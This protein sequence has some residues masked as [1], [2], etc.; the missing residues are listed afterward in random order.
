MPVISANKITPPPPFDGGKYLN[1]QRE[2]QF[3]RDIYWF[4]DD[5]Q[6]L[7]VTG[8]HANS[9]LRKFLIQFFRQT[10]EDLRKRTIKE[11]LARMLKHFSATVKEREAY[12]VGE[13]LP[14]KRESSESIQGFWFKYDEM[15]RNLHGSQISMPDTVMFPRVLKALNISSNVRLSLI[16]RLDC[17][18]MGH[19]IENLR[20]VTI[21]LM[22]V[23]KEVLGKG[24]NVHGSFA[25]DAQLSDD[26]HVLM[27]K[28]LAVARAKKKGRRPS[29]RRPQ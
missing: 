5:N 12:Y 14:M 11:F 3:W 19:T 17:Q 25:I 1:W 4:V 24:E 27:G 15:M 10:R 9:S 18:G 23:Y 20:L 29:R 21:E 7:S 6:L 16:T 28:V 8:L 22:G 2:Y 13:L 26:E